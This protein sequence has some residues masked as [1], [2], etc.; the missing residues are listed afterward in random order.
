MP[1]VPTYDTPQVAIRPVQT[2]YQDVRT[3]ADDFG[4]MTGR[5]LEA[6]GGQAMQVANVVDRRAE[7]M[8]KEN[9]AAKALEVYSQASERIR[10]ALH[11]PEK[12]IYTR[13]GKN[14][15]G[16]YDEVG[17]VYGDVEKEFTAQLGNDDQRRAFTAMW[18]RRRDND[19]E[20]VS[21]HVASEREKWRIETAGAVVKGAVDDAVNNFG[22]PQAIGLSIVSA[23]AA[24]RAN[25]KGQSAEVI[26]EMERNAVS[27]IHKGVVE[28]MAI[29]NPTA[30]KAY[31]EK[32][33]AG[34]DGADHIHLE[35]LL[36]DGV[37]RQVA[38]Q[39][40][41]AIMRGRDPLDLSG[42][43]AEARKITDPN[44][45]DDVERRVHQRFNEAKAAR[46]EVERG[47]RQE[48]WKYAAQPG[49]KSVD[50]IPLNVWSG[51]DGYSQSV[52]QKHLENK[53]KGVEPPANPSLY[54][55]LSG[56]AGD[57]PGKFVDYDLTQHIGQLPSSDYE[58][59]VDLQRN[60]KLGDAKAV[61]RGE[62]YK[63]AMS[64]AEI[65][66]RAAG[67]DPTITDKD[68]KPKAKKILE[69]QDALFR[70]LDAL[71][72]D[73]G[74]R[75]T[76][77]EIRGTVDRLL[78][79]GRIRGTQVVPLIGS[80]D[81]K[82]AF[83]REDGAEFYVPYSAIPKKERDV[84][85]DRL[86]SRGLPHDERAVEDAYTAFKLSRGGR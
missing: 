3:S 28:R 80:D 22:N 4:A 6:A 31:Y 16:A 42:A 82:F 72:K 62:N 68:G 66:L 5:A 71:H 63:R 29:D 38:Q 78:I 9:D 43:L 25:L 41:D 69:F 50:Q 79:K 61:E 60:M 7:Q 51:L 59:F 11:D 45:R 67:M 77:E 34:V 8:K 83:Q 26:E 58:K 2:P 30:A 46:D 32:N 85:V 10:G 35:K 47:N 74:K 56:L 21:R 1:R 44:V 39:T 40:T 76:D 57:S 13:R 12:G 55:K 27:Q 53:A 81:A 14:A 73:K 65:P 15:L 54:S 19:L 18:T 33:K 23:R 70:E 75:L 49:V 17:K 84:M 52:I 20:G 86:K 36:K 64:L 37:T 48:A 24:I